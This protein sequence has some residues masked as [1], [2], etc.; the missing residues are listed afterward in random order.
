MFLFAN[1]KKKDMVDVC[2]RAE[3]RLL[4]GVFIGKVVANLRL[5]PS[6]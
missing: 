5:Y 1:V 6:H 3:G 4:R 2:E